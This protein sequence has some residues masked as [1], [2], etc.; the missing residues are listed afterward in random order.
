MNGT[1]LSVASRGLWDRHTKRWTDPKRQK[2]RSARLEKGIAEWFKQDSLPAQTI[3]AVL[4]IVGVLAGIFLVI[5]L[6][7]A[8]QFVALA[9]GAVILL[10]ARQRYEQAGVALWALAGIGLL[11]FC[12][13]LFEAGTGLALGFFPAFATAVIVV[14]MTTRIPTLVVILMGILLTV[15][16]LAAM[17]L[18]IEG[19]WL[20]AIGLI[21]LL[22]VACLVGFA[23]FCNGREL[24]VATVLMAMI[25]TEWLL[26]GAAGQRAIF[27]NISSTSGLHDEG[28]FRLDYLFNVAFI[29]A[30]GL[31]VREI[32]PGDLAEEPDKEPGPEAVLAEL[33]E[34]KRAVVET[35]WPID[36]YQKPA[37]IDDAKGRRWNSAALRVGG[38]TEKEIEDTGLTH[39]EY[40]QTAKA[41]A[42]AELAPSARPSGGL[43]LDVSDE[44][45][46]NLLKDLS[47]TH[48]DLK[49]ARDEL[50]KTS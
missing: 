11:G 13:V 22:L 50:E 30:L 2:A 5:K 39:D 37:Q 45:R 12:L 26:F 23:G 25:L 10:I 19:Q 15:V 29:M 31:L 6:L 34:E 4:R 28:V 46:K 7:L 9:I 18:D 8:G 35:L 41:L 49:Q 27:D 43:P 14:L 32:R 24:L 3:R 36:K 1:T 42:L 44:L 16:V 33:S 38:L 20:L 40:L 17:G 47:I 21:V 48:I